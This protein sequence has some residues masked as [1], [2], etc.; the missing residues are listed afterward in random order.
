MYTLLRLSAEDP[1][2]HLLRR[3]D[4]RISRRLEDQGPVAEHVERSD[5]LCD[6]V[7]ADKH[8]AR[9]LSPVNKQDELILAYSF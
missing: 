8:S 4:G 5:I 3:N 2:V 1:R 6:G 7:I 9:A